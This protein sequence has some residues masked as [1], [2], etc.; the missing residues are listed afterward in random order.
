ML[1]T[2]NET[3]TD[4][5][6]CAETV[7]NDPQAATHRVYFLYC[8]G[9]IKI[10]VTSNIIKRMTNLQVAIPFRSQT[11]L[12]IPG[13]FLTE[14]YMHFIF[15]EYRHQGEWFRFGPKLRE[16]IERLSLPEYKE[17]LEEEESAHKEWVKAEASAL[18]F[19]FRSWEMVA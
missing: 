1:K 7:P 4:G 18:G 17:W 16:T 9:F 14:Q 13:G 12:L 10:G 2:M 5:S 6:I 3:G 15:S 19:L 11:I 8:A